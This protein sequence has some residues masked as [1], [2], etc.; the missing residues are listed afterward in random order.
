M[1][2]NYGSREKYVNEVV[3]F[4]SRLDELQAALLRVKL[5]H[6]D[7]WNGRRREMAAAYLDRLAASGLGLP[8]V[9]AGSEP[10]WHLFVVRSPHRQFFLDALTQQGIG[11]LI[12][13]PIAPH[14][15]EAYR[16]LGYRKGAFPVAERLA[17]EVFSI[18]IG[19][20]LAAHELAAVAEALQ[21]VV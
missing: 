4:N 19:P 11:W 12:H 18:P 14:M 6:L 20:H 8:E 21:R 10:V 1:L 13:Y 5:R 9:L 15:Q 7:E 3:G 17:D 16:P 2:R